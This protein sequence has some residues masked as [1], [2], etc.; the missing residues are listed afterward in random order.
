MFY[1]LHVLSLQ[2]DVHNSAID[3][4]VSVMADT[5]PELVIPL[6]DRNN[7]TIDWVYVNDLIA[8]IDM[9]EVM[10]FM[11]RRQDASG[12]PIDNS[13]IF[14]NMFL[15]VSDYFQISKKIP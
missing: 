5:V 10:L 9:F 15:R 13:K 1:H 12:Y 7:V 3:Y 6:E 4:T 2:S 11:K 14:G 8:N